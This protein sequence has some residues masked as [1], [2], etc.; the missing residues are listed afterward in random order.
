MHAVFELAKTTS[1]FTIT[2]FL[3]DGI[4]VHFTDKSK[5]ETWKK[6]MSDAVARETQHF[7]VDTFLEW[8]REPIDAR[9]F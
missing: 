3:H 7:G 1:D 5:S 8:E 4:A 2:L 6:R 9:I